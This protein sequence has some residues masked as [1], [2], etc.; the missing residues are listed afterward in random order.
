MQVRPS[1]YTKPHTHN[2]FDEI[3]ILIGDSLR[4]LIQLGEE[5]YEMEGNHSIWIPAGT[6]HAANVIQGSGYFVAI[7][8]EF[9]K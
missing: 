8:L 6:L 1:P 9:R 5:T 7:R 4:Y 3:N 2:D